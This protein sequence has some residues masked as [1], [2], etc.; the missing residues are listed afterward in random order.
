MF[1]NVIYI[2]IV[3]VIF[4]I[5][6]PGEG[7]IKSP[8]A[9]SGLFIILWIGFAF[10][11]KYRFSTQTELK[12]RSAFNDNR[13]SISYHSAVTRLSVLA[14]IVFALYVYLINLKY[15]L[16]KIPGFN[17]FSILPGTVAV[18]IFL[19]LLATVWYYGYDAYCG[20]SNLS[21]ERWN[22]IGSNIKLNFPIIFPWAV[23]TVFYDM[24]TFFA[25]PPLKDVFESKLGQIILLTIF[26]ILLV[27]FLPLLIK[28]WWGC[29]TLPASEKKTAIIKLFREAGFRCRDIVKWPI[30]GGHI[31]TAGIMGLVPKFRY[32][33]VTDALINI[34]SEEELKAVM[35]HEIGHIKYRHIV[36]Y[37]LFLLGYLIISVGIFDFLFY[38]M[39]TKP[40]LIGLLNSQEG[41]KTSVFYF[42]FSLP[43]IVSIILYFRYIMG[44]FMRN[45][46]RQADL[47]SAKLMGT[48]K[49]IVMSLEKIAHVTGQN[50]HQPSWHHFSIA[51]RVEFLWRYF[52]HPQIIK[53]HSRRLA[54][55]LSIFFIIIGSIAYA[56]NFGPM[57]KDINNVFLKNILE[58]KLAESPD[59]IEIYR[60]LASLYHSNN[61]IGKAVWAYENILR[62]YPDD[63]LAL[64]N[65][66]WILAT[67]KDKKLLN[68]PKALAL[69][70]KAVD[71]ER[72]ATF[73]DTLS[74]AYYVNG[75]YDQAIKVIKE[76]LDNESGDRDYLKGQLN[77]FKRAAGK[78]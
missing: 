8:A 30:M 70:K 19:A 14:I 53:R 51:E 59:N 67:A 60:I 1:N 20:F 13:A 35:A 3:L 45:F 27:L 36:F 32:I 39:A 37:G 69:A 31:M 48:V 10:F 7:F 63:K 29:S 75:F 4:T 50:R 25:W 57:K 55:F 66:A 72:S 17:T 38:A 33:L 61:N 73:L 34:L 52:R 21:V 78:K 68:Y 24:V 43:V 74:E 46:E 26:L 40:W 77:R 16:L 56:V 11:C 23:L 5:N 12:K 42:V 9:A 64:N 18:L 49:P 71:F 22:F 76:A 62:L 44:F 47:Y 6:Y 28:S 2:I 15:W 54:I 58:N 41:Y 65:L